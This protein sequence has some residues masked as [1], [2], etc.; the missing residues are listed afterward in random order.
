MIIFRA[1][2]VLILV[3]N[4]II[5]GTRKIVEGMFIFKLIYDCK[6]LI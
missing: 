5:K 2:N 3:K 1:I 4:I 6:T